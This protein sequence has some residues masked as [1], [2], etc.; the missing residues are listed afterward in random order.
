M[1]K[2]LLLLASAALLL[3]GCA[4]EKFA[5]PSDGGLTN[6]TFSA[7]VDGGVATKAAADNDG[8]GT[9]VNRCIMEIYFQNQLYKRMEAAMSGTPATA[10]FSNVPVVAG[11]QYEILF[12]ADHVDV[13]N[14]EAGLATDKYYTTKTTT[15][16]KGL[17]AVTVNKTNFIDALQNKKNDELDAFFFADNYTVP[18]G[19]KSY[20]AKLKRPFAQLNVITTDVASGKTV[21]SADLLPETVTVSYTAATT[22][23]VAD[24]LASGSTTYTYTA[25]VYGDKTDWPAVKTLGEFTLSMDYILAA[26]E[27]SMVDVSFQTSTGMSHSLTSLPYQRNYRT[28]VKGDLL[29]AGGTWTAKI[30]TIWSNP[31]IV[32]VVEVADI[33]SANEIIEQYAETTKNLEVKFVGVPNDS[34][35]PSG[36]PESQF[37]AIL[38]SPLKQ[39]ANLG[40]EVMTSTNTLYVGDYKVEYNVDEL[41]ETAELNA[42]TVNINVPQNSGIQT[43]IINAP[44]KTVYVNGHRVDGVGEITNIDAITSMNTLIIEPGQKVGKLTMR[45]GGLEI[46]GTVDEAIVPSEHGSIS[47]RDCENLDETKVYNILQPHID[48]NYIGVKD[49]TTHGL[50]DIVPI[51][52]KIGTTG[53]GSLADAVAAV[54]TNGSETTI[55]MVN[56][57]ATTEK[58]TI[59]AAK[60]VVLDLNGKKISYTTDGYGSFIENR[61]QLKIKDSGSTGIITAKFSAP[62]WNN[63]CYTI[64]NFGASPASK[65]VIESGTIEN[66]SPAGLAWPIN[67]GSWGTSAD[68]VI[69]GGTIHSVNYVP[70]REY[71]QYGGKKTIV[72]N[73]GKLISDNSRAIAVQLNDATVADQGSYVEINGGEFSCNGSGILYVDLHAANLN[74]TGFTMTVNGGKFK[75]ANADAP[76]LVYDNEGNDQSSAVLLSNVLKGGVY[77][78]KPADEIVAEGRSVKE[79]ADPV[80]PWKV[81]LSEPFFTIIFT[82]GSPSK[83]FNDVFAALAAAKEFE[84]SGANGQAIITHSQYYDGYPNAF[85]GDSYIPIKQYTGEVEER[86]Y[87]FGP[88]LST[89]SY[90]NFNLFDDSFGFYAFNPKKTLNHSDGS[91]V[92]ELEA[93]MALVNNENVG[94]DLSNLS[95]LMQ[96]MIESGMLSSDEQNF[97]NVYNLVRSFAFDEYGSIQQ[98]PLSLA[99]VFNAD[100]PMG[101]VI[102]SGHYAN[103][104]ESFMGHGWVNMEM[105]EGSGT[106]VPEYNQ[107]MYGIYPYSGQAEDNTLPAGKPV[108]MPMNT[109]PYNCS[110]YS[111][112]NHF[113]DWHPVFADYL[114]NMFVLDCA[115]TNLSEGNTGKK[116]TA[117]VSVPLSEKIIYV[118]GS[119]E[120]TLKSPNE[121]RVFIA[122]NNYDIY[123]NTVN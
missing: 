1:K 122:T 42:A 37:R 78:K 8:K 103:G 94:T 63:G 41:K 54:P 85:L 89:R 120:Y 68:L 113:Y 109:S 69:N 23:N 39:G 34:G 123:T 26:K 28:N 47:V 87:K 21:I 12:W 88:V 111:Q 3:V 51:L 5:E 107:W 10:T 36:N 79:N 14:T 50:W 93:V 71:L 25:P 80:Y 4:K 29:T 9:N 20:T 66:T 104:Y 65:L 38:T 53:Y 30:D 19:G 110:V 44:T 64:D 121:D 102:L 118:L 77:S 7:S 101:S 86:E 81:E 43:L 16:N 33:K 119:K 2:T 100:I 114:D 55:T 73:G 98:I 56:D 112:Y 105:G 96:M 74:T 95:G 82:N 72:I 84:E 15:D 115:V 31:D 91:K 60:N 11:K 22:F 108:N 70:V 76:V 67:N 58:V 61:G 17:K 99:A 48:E 27:K 13:V 46:H 75:N 35:E 40:I 59:A 32:K 92:S 6:V 62:N 116:M 97:M 24:S 57:F 83:T 106:S 45:Q 90:D 117:L 18:Q 49:R 52:C